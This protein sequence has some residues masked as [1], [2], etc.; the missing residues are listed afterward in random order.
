MFWYVQSSAFSL[1]PAFFMKGDPD[2]AQTHGLKIKAKISAAVGVGTGMMI[3][4][5]VVFEVHEIRPLA[6]FG[7]RWEKSI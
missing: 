3:H 1:Q 4:A 7:Q 6:D 2:A 5:A